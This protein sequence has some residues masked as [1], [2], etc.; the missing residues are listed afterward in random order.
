MDCSLPGSSVHGILQARILEWVAVPSSR[1]SSQPR[2][3]TCLSRMAGG[4]FTKAPPGKLLYR[5]DSWML[6][7]LTQQ[8]FLL[9]R[10]PWLR[11]P[12]LFPRK[13]WAITSIRT[14]RCFPLLH[15]HPLEHALTPS[16]AH[17]IVSWQAAHTD[18]SG[19]RMWRKHNQQ[20]FPSWTW[21]VGSERTFPPMCWEAASSLLGEVLTAGGNPDE[22]KTGKGTR[23]ALGSWLDA[24]S[25]HLYAWSH[26]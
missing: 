10:Q 12:D 3:G 4:F 7:S 26:R 2:N 13:A 23:V 19:T 6:A 20:E 5:D 11:L 16:R 9:Q 14:W 25:R 18:C 15:T 22:K 8:I 1:G 17:V 24:R 21:E